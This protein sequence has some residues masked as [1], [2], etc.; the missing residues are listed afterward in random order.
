ML[1]GIRLEATQPPSTVLA[2]YDDLLKA[3]PANVAVWKRR[4]SVLRRLGLVE[5]AVEELCQLLDTFYTDLEGWLELA[6]LYS[7]C[8]EYVVLSCLVLFLI[9]KNQVHPRAS[10]TFTCPPPCAAKP[11]YVPSICR[12]GIHIR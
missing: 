10:S 11:V 6:D 8:N 4:I 7:S 1:T 2:Y 3:E 9:I 5:K 12:N